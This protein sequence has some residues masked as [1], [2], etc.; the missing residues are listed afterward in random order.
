MFTSTW[1]VI[2]SALLFVSSIF[3]TCTGLS[4]LCSLNPCLAT[5]FLSMNIPIASLSK[6]AFTITPSWVSTFST[7][8]FNHTSLNIL[9]VL[10]TSLCSPPS[11]ATPFGGLLYALP[12]C[13]F[14]CA[15]C[16]TLLSFLLCLG[17]PHHLAFS[18]LLPL[19]TPCSL[20]SS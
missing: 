15:G 12:G 3:L 19:R 6:S 17:Y 2:T 7:P 14:P 13:T 10:L 11:L 16:T 18:N 8:I 4:N 9:N 1:C 20:L 5:I